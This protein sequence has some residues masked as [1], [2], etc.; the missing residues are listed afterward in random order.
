MGSLTSG[1]T[2]IYERDNGVIY[3]RE[4][5]ADPSTRKAIGWDYDYKKERSP[6]QIDLENHKLWNEIRTAAKT[7]IALQKAIENV[8]LLYRLSQNNPL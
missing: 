8:I 4:F 1:A 3:A 2:Y 7:N 6:G 5:G